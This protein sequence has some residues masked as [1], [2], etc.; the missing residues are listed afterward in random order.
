MSP[1]D[2][3]TGLQT[4]CFV[5][6]NNKL[7]FNTTRL[8]FKYNECLIIKKIRI[9]QIEFHILNVAYFPQIFLLLLHFL[10]TFS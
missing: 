7:K 8:R 6:N 9:Q 1:L 5:L 10:D 3:D 4:Q 2:D